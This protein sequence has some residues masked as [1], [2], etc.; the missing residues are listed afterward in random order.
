MARLYDEMT[1]FGG[2]SNPELTEAVCNYLG[3]PRGR[4]DVFKFSNDNTFVRIGESKRLAEQDAA[5][6]AL[7]RLGV[8]SGPQ[9]VAPVRKRRKPARVKGTAERNG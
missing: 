7:E 3:L 9:Q 2:N 5:G 1:I 6:Q 4:A 8:Q